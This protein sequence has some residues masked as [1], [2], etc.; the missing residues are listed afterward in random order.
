MSRMIRAVVALIATV[1]A[2]AVLVAPSPAVAAEPVWERIECLSGTLDDAPV[3][4]ETYALAQ[5]MLSGSLD[6][7]AFGKATFG[8][9]RYDSRNFQGLAYEPYMRPYAYTAPTSFSI[10]NYVERGPVDFAL[11]VVT[12][13]EVRIACVRVTRENWESK[14]YAFHIKTVDPMVDRP[15]RVV[16]KDSSDRP[17]CG[18]CW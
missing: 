16:P 7:A 4:Q 1:A 6:C 13:Y 8:F 11:C 17:A 18:H 9:A 14:L 2:M 3:I 10:S 5:V 12:D 15:V